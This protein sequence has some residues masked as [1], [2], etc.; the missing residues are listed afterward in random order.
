M[1]GGDGFERADTVDAFA[2]LSDSDLDRI[3]RQRRRRKGL[4]R[5]ASPVN[6]TLSDPLPYGDGEVYNAMV[7]TGLPEGGASTDNEAQYTGLAP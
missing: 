1:G 4:R 5:S 3:E 2:P 6:V 7:I